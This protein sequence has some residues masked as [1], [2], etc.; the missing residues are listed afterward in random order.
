MPSTYCSGHAGGGDGDG[1]V[2]GGLVRCFAGHLDAFGS[3]F[4]GFIFAVKHMRQVGCHLHC[5]HC[6]RPGG[7][8]AVIW[9]LFVIGL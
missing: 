3:N 7:H 5:Q 2:V 6:W 4:K 8:D 9:V 1:L